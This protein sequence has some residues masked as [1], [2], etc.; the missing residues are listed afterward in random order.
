MKKFLLVLAAALTAFVAVAQTPEEILEKM[1]Q[2]MEKGEA[3]GM[4]MTMTMKIPVLGSFPTKMYS[5]GKNSRA[6]VKAMGRQLILW[7]DSG[8]TWTYDK[9]KEEITIEYDGP[10]SSSDAQEGLGM[11]DGVED[12]YD[13]KLQKETADSWLIICKKSKGNTNEDDPKKIEIAVYKGSYILKEM[14]A[15]MKG[16]TMIINDVKFGVKEKDVTFDASQ[17]PNATIIDKREKK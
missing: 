10:D 1:D 15:S 3:E 12:G 14:R 8:T 6:E 2:A 16:V 17:F 7:E 13:L 9:K 5:L 11:L 4:V